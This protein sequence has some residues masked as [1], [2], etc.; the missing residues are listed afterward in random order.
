MGWP[1]HFTQSPAQSPVAGHTFPP[2]EHGALGFFF[3]IVL[4]HCDLI[5]STF[6]NPFYVEHGV[7]ISIVKQSKPSS[8]K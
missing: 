3:L 7:I 1:P 6:K 4:G 8:R 2:D 5:Y